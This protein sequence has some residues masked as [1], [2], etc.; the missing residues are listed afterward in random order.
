MI[1]RWLVS[2]IAL[3]SVLVVFWGA[4]STFFSDLPIFPFPMECV[5]VS[6]LILLLFILFPC[7]YS[8]LSNR[9]S[10]QA[11]LVPICL[12]LSQHFR[13]PL[14]FH[15]FFQTEERFCS[16]LLHLALFIA[17]HLG[18]RVC[19]SPEFL[20]CATDQKCPA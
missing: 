20:S 12:Q 2:P 18:L 1:H 6:V 17:L 7:L 4:C 9:A 3:F 5:Q 19:L 11:T 16:L 14:S 13:N 15:I 8:A 10:L